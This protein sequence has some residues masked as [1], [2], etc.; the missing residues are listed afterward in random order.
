MPSTNF[1][2]FADFS[3]QDF[4]VGIDVHKKSWTV[5]VRSLRLQVAHFTQP[6]S[7]DILAGYLTK[8]F[9]KGNYFS[10]YEAGFFGTTTH[11]QLCSL[12]IKNIIVHPGDIPATDKQKKTKTDLHDSRSLAEYLEKNDLKGIH[13][14]P[15]QQQELRALFR[16]RISKS[17]D[18]TRAVNKLK[19]FLIY[20]G[21][22]LP[23]S[24]NQ[25]AYLSKASLDW[26]NKL[27]LNTQ[28]GNLSQK[29]YLQDVL[30][31]RERLLMIT[32]QLRSQV[33]AHYSKEYEYLVSV[34]GIG[35]LTAVAFLAEIG[36]F[37]RFK[38]PDQ[39][40]S[41]LGL[42]PWENSS[43]QTLRTKGLQPRSNHYLRPLL[44]EASWSAIRKAPDL[45]LY[46]RKHAIKSS[47]R[48]VVKVAR[49]LALIARGVVLKQQLYD[50]SYY[51]QRNAVK[52]SAKA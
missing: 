35:P 22:E 48:A 6:P 29:E 19:G 33:Q 3:N 32:R 14:L 9:P 27:E 23:G 34:P 18:L 46:Y 12:G 26:L 51:N 30:Y 1:Q 49:K 4:Y 45:L 20:F 21:V 8:K 13:V 17:R 41:F 39:F 2:H 47:K 44:I 7:P 38:D 36:D 25:A 42:M 40:C 28:A 43:R 31:R 5:T 10:V 15:R 37:N 24:W 50:P 52:S 16:L 11:E